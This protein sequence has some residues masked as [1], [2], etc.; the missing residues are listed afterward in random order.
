MSPAAGRAGIDERLQLASVL[1]EIGDLGAGEASLLRLLADQPQDREALSLL[2]KLKHIRG[3]LSAAFACWAQIHTLAPEGQGAHMRLAS[4]LR[5]AQDPERGAGEFLALGQNQLWRKPAALLEL[6]GAFRLFVALRPDEARAACS[7]LAQKSRE[8]DRDLYKLAVLAEAWIAELAGDP[9]RAAEALE[10]LG[11]E[12]GFAGDTDRALALLRVYEVLGRAEDI[13]KAIHVCEYL[14]RTLHGFERVS[15]LGRLAA[16]CR[17]AGRQA[18]AVDY[19]Q[20]FLLAFQT[21]MHRPT[22]ADALAAAAQQY[23]PLPRLAAASFVAGADPDPAETP[24][25]SAEIP[26]QAHPRRRALSL[27]L[28]GERAAAR[29]LLERGG[30]VLDRKYLADLALLEGRQEAAVRLFLGTL[31]EDPGDPRVIGWL[32]DHAEGGASG[33]TAAEDGGASIR[34]HFKSPERAGQAAAV[35]EAQI[36]ESPRRPAAWRQLAVLHRLRGDAPEAR[37]CAERAAA[38]A[39]AALRRESA[40]GRVLSAAV[41]HFAGRAKGL[42]HEVWAAR[43]PV[44][45]GQ[46]GFLD[47][48]LGNLTSELTQAVRNTFLAVREY[49]RANL[50]HLTGDILDFNYSFKVTKEDEP[51]G[52]LSAGLPTALAFLSV[53]LDRPVPQDLASSGMLVT[54]AHDVLVV[55]PVG[56]AEWKVRGAYNRNLRLV[57]LPE[58]NRADLERSIQVPRPISAQLVRFVPDLDSA[59]R[60]VFP[61]VE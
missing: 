7:R 22:L 18:E 48:I 52:G 49:A 42:I 3:E 35:L 47:E 55:R 38:L 25:E 57:I 39:T 50:P 46:G 36:R 56:E 27:A 8:Q 2:A 20:Q 23:L 19:D 34:R 33:A 51:S 28:A 61:D 13:E 44:A 15:A 60:L 29:A 6:E 43:K 59:V 24:A 11:N 45:P 17:A 10:Q 30:E 58:G 41:Y 1:V 31:G 53:F 40:V 5:L 12:R 54:D 32:L 9:A 4:M 16:L 26:A 14:L 37:R 21:V